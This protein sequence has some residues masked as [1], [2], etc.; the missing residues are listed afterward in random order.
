MLS[1]APKLIEVAETLAAA[2][3]A[4]AVFTSLKNTALSL[5]SERRRGRSPDGTEIDIV[6]VNV[7]ELRAAS[8]EIEE[9]KL[10]IDT[11]IRK[12]EILAEKLARSGAQDG[13]AAQ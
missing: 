11:L 5:F 9:L 2:L 4:T 10:K 13:S 12:N 8:A 1:S 7:Q 3:F 6:D